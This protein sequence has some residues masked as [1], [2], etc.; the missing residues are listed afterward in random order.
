MSSSAIEEKQNTHR[1]PVFWVICFGAILWNAGGLAN[2]LWQLNAD[3]VASFP[4]PAQAIIEN[5]PLWATAAFGFGMV[6]GTVGCMLLLFRSPKAK[7]LLY[8]SLV[9]VLITVIHSI[10]IATGNDLFGMSEN[11]TMIIAPVFVAISLAWYARSA[12]VRGMA[13]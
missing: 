12:T 10:M 9:S 3:A 4:A 11:F 7:N 8:F 2:F 6:T 1:H 13:S 5:R